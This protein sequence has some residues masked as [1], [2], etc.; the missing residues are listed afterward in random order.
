MSVSCGLFKTIGR[1][2][3][4]DVRGRWLS[5]LD[6]WRI[7]K[8]M[9]V[10]LRK[11][12]VPLYFVLSAWVRDHA[13]FIMLVQFVLPTLALVTLLYDFTHLEL[14]MVVGAGSYD[15]VGFVLLTGEDTGRWLASL[16][17]LLRI[18]ALRL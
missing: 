2:K 18:L 14:S 11:D 4:L 3:V 6:T 1:L 9:R 13:D 7:D 17:C 15:G 12:L 8:G 16:C 5:G 10:R